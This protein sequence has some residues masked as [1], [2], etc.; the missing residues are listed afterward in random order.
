MRQKLNEPAINSSNSRIFQQPMIPG[1]KL[2][3]VPGPVIIGA[4]PSGLAAAACL[5]TKE[6]PFLILEKGS[7]LASLWQFGT[8]DRLQLHLPKKF[9]ELPFFP[10]P[11]HFPAY[12]TKQQF[13]AY[14]EAYAKHFAIKPVF[15]QEARAVQYDPDMGFWQVQACGYEFICRWVIVATGENADPF[16]PEI[17]GLGDFR[18]RTLHTS[19]YRDGGEFKGKKVLVV[20]C[21]NSGMEVS[22]DLFDNGADVSLFVR[23]KLHILPR[24]ILGIS[25][26]ALSMLLLKWFPVKLVDK[27]L[28][29]VSRLILGDTSRSGIKRPDI[30]PLELKNST[31]KTPVLDFGAFA[32]IKSGQI[33]IVRGIRRFTTNG[34]EF[35]DGRVKEFDAAILATGYRSN[36]TSWLKEE[37]FFNEKDGYPRTPFPNSWKGN[38]GL[39]CIGFT[40]RGLLGTSIDAQKVA[41]DIARQ[42]NS[43]TRHLKVES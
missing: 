6:I 9:C 7:C 3:W 31:G 1:S 20:G 25:T 15:R 26:F 2:V 39:Y 22:L 32:R 11:P 4:G 17:E 42:W 19:S 28:I 18:G 12:P 23:D 16:L 14:L 41:E 5:K 35:V 40:K 43:E 36:V 30:G 21:G 37:N 34:V 27:F 13:I 38:N 24:E 33:K 29:F 10:F 8:Y